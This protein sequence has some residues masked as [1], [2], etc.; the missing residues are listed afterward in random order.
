[1]RRALLLASLLALP[2]SATRPPSP[3]KALVLEASRLF[4]AGSGKRAM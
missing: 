3:P 4:D 2:A 1:M